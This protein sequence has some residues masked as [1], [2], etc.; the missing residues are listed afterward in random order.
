MKTP[1]KKELYWV[2]GTISLTLTV[3]LI[4]FG[5]K[6]FN[7]RLLDLQVHDSYFIFHKYL[8]LTA[9][10]IFLL[11]GMYL[12]R[13]IFNILDNRVVSI[14]V[15]IILTFILI[16]LISYSNWIYGH[17]KDSGYYSFDERSQ[18]ERI[19]E[20]TMTHW[21]L[22]IMIIVTGVTIMTT[23]YKIVRRKGID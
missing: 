18:T 15:A 12:N 16:G 2:L 5:D 21:V 17:V 4:I 1:L 22:T 13:G 3:G 8:F 6:L 10:F 7:G 9:I 23:G 20:Y 19:S 14:L 11:G